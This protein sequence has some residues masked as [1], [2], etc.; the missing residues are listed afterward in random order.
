MKLDKIGNWASIVGLP[1]AA[2]I[3]FI[4]WWWKKEEI[5]SFYQS[6]QVSPYIFFYVII[7][8]L[9]VW[10]VFL[11]IQTKKSKNKK[12]KIIDYFAEYQKSNLGK[13]YIEKRKD[14]FLVKRT[15]KSIKDFVANNSTQNLKSDIYYLYLF[16]LLTGTEDKVWA[17]S[18]GTEWDDSEEEKE[19]LRLNFEVADKRILLERIFVIDKSQVNTLKTTDP[20]YEQ[21]KRSGK[22]LK[23]YI[24]FK[25]DISISDRQLLQQ[26][27]EGFLAFDDYAIAQD[28]FDD[29]KIR[30]ELSADEETIKRY[31]RRFN[32]LRHYAKFVNEKILEK[33]LKEQS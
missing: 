4:F 15:E 19:F 5:V 12:R 24:A 10:L 18:M 31:S 21:I 26:I 29:G 20:I 17:V 6:F 30:G 13:E 7:L 1:L 16:S 11:L 8:I 3:S 2:I 25:E 33:I 23:T 27:G 28:V 9:V 32:S 22:F 14:D